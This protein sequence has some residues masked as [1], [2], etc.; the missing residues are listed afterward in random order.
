MFLVTAEIHLLAALNG[1]GK[2]TLARRLEATLPA[3]RFSL[4]EWML[5][6]YGTSFDDEHDPDLAESAAS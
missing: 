4:D 5:R 1:A 3:A 2:T 6:L